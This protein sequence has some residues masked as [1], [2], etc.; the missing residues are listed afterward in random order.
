MLLNFVLTQLLSDSLTWRNNKVFAVDKKV[1]NLSISPE[2]EKTLRYVAGF[3]PF[4]L[5]KTYQ[6]RSGIL[7]SSICELLDSWRERTD[8]APNIHDVLGYTKT[9]VDRVDRGGLFKVNN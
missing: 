4:S 3:I 2:E 9:W 7:S 5:F 1:L 6:Q 8:L